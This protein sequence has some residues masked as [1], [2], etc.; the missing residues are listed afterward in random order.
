MGCAKLI[1]PLLSRAEGG[2]GN[3]VFYWMFGLLNPSLGNK[4]KELRNVLIY[5]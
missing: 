2:L 3:I 4:I 5:V 1:G